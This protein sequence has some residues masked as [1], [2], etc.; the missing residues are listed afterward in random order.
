[1]TCPVCGSAM[2][3]RSFVRSLLLLLFVSSR[4]IEFIFKGGFVTNSGCF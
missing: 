2:L 3:V 1:M 4:S